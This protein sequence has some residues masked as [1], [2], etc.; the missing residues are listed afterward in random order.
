MSFDEISKFLS[1]LRS[2]QTVWLFP[3]AFA[4][5]VLEEAPKFT[6]WVYKYASEKFTYS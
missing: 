6:A 3:L 1:D 4:L 5:H 2:Y